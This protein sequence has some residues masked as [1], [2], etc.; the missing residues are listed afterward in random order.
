MRRSHERDDAL[1]HTVDY[2]SGLETIIEEPEPVR[3]RPLASRC[4]EDPDN[5]CRRSS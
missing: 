5:E 4:E 3:L 2:R 1:M